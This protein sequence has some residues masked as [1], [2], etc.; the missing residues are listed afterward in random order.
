MFAL[1]MEPYEMIQVSMLLQPHGTVVANF[2]PGNF[3]LFGG[4]PGNH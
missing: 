2:V 3:G 4:T 1:L